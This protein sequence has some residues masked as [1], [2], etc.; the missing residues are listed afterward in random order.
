MKTQR[1]GIGKS[2]DDKHTEAV[3]LSELF[4]ELL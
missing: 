1:I 2:K 4:D 3:M